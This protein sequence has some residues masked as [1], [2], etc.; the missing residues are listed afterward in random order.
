MNHAFHVA[1]VVV[2]AYV[3]IGLALALFDSIMS[4]HVGWREVLTVT[5]AWPLCLLG[6][7]V[8]Y[9]WPGAL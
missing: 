3:F 4:R 8:D 1:L 7:V 2:L 5:T 6:M 9:L